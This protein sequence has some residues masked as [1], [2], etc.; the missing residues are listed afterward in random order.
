MSPKSSEFFKPVELISDGKAGDA[1]DRA[2]KAI[3]TSVGDKVFD[4]LKGIT[5]EE[6]QKIS[7]IR[8]TAQKAEA[9]FVAKIQQSGRESPEG[10]E[11]FRGMISNKVLKL[12]ALLLIMESDIEKNGST[13]VSSDTPDEVKK[14]LNKN[15]SLDKAAAGQTQKG[16][17]G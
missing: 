4:D 9:T 7:T 6:E 1:F 11:Y 5:S 15:I 14:L 10:L 12:T 8:V 13:H 17:D 16:V 3:T 2:K